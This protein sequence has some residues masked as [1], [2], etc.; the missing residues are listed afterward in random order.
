MPRPTTVDGY[1]AA[2][3][4]EARSMLKQLR[5]AIRSAVPAAEEKLSYGMPYYFHHGRL[6]YFAAFREHVSYYVMPGKATTDRYAVRI[7]PYKM[8]KATLRFPLGTAIPIGLIKSLVRARAK[9]NEA[10]RRGR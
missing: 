7:E 2:A 4:K 6:A 9:E 10:K 1:I 3:P 8:G 5:A